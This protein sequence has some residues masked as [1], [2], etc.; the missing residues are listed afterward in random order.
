MNELIPLQNAEPA[1]LFA[2]GGLDPIIEAIE[3][4]ARSL[5][6]DISTASGR[7]SVASNAA[8]VAKAKTY[9]DDIGKSYVAELKELPKKIDAAR[10]SMR[11]RLDALKDE[12]R[13]PLT[14]YEAAQQRLEDAI[15]QTLANF[16]KEPD[17]GASSREI[18]AARDW[19]FEFDLNSVEWMGRLD[20][21]ISV[22]DQMIEL[23]NE[24]LQARRHYEELIERNRQLEQ[25]RADRE[26]AERER[27]IAEQA[28]AKARAEMAREM[29]SA[30]IEQ[31]A[32][33]V[34][35]MAQTAG[36]SIQS[37]VEKQ[38]EMATAVS[39]LSDGPAF[40]SD[41]PFP[42][43]EPIEALPMP[44]P[45]MDRLD[46]LDDLGELFGAELAD[47]IL[48][49]IESGKVSNIKASWT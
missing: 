42:K 46:A 26:R 7:K 45:A 20:E 6:P 25:E 13:A 30:S 2:P 43:D 19:L 24:R 22:R 10:K 34:R 14:E 35:Q 38:A 40:E 11:D 47:R 5:V 44:N 15:N 3:R 28:A 31:V 18:Q 9:L 4:E 27:Q 16:R 29:T 21:A 1:I 49:A 17:N 41:E 8:K 48:V 23:L 33:E 39:D 37:L 36:P 32:A 12:V